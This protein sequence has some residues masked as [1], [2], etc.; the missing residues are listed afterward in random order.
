MKLIHQRGDTIVEVLLAMAV[1]GLIMGGA[2]ASARRSLNSTVQA[3]EHTTALKLAEGQLEEIKQISENVSTDVNS[4]YYKLYNT[5]NIF[6]ATNTSGLDILDA[7]TTTPRKVFGDITYD[8]NFLDYH[9]NCSTN[10]GIPY[11]I[12]ITRSTPENIFT[13]YVRWDNV[14]G[15]G[16]DQVTLVYKLDK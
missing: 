10:S 5:G 2:F 9:V 3:K 15:T 13:V 16:Q 11:Y 7:T 14:H 1:L 12:G 6:C 4:A 8:I